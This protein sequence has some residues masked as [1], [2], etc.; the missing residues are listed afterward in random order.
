MAPTRNSPPDYRSAQ[1]PDGRTAGRRKGGY[2]YVPLSASSYFT[3][4]TADGF[5]PE[6]QARL[7]DVARDLKAR[8][9]AVLPSPVRATAASLAPPR[10]FH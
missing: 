4:Y 8:G 10:A 5:G 2:P 7:R 6:E 3:S 1:R 9:V